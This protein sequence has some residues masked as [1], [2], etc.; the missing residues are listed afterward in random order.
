M[1]LLP[2]GGADLELNSTGSV[3]FDDSLDLEL[4]L[5]LPDSPLG[6]GPITKFLTNNP[7]V[8][9]LVGSVADPQVQLASDNGWQN[10]LR[11]MLDAIGSGADEASDSLNADADDTNDPNGETQNAS[12][13]AIETTGTVLD[14]FGDL[15]N[16]GSEREEPSAPT[17]R[18]RI[19]NRGDEESSPPRRPGRLRRSRQQE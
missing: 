11:S 18:D 14:I 6:G 9:R 13:Y 17:S 12:E 3:G 5:G 10:R 4:A 16:R 1:F 19:R 7:I 15:L 2:V 8:I